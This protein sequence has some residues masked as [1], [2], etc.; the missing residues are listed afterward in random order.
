MVERQAT[1]STLKSYHVSVK[2]NKQNIISKS[3][4]FKKKA[5]AEAIIFGY[6][7]MR[8]ALVSQMKEK[9]MHK[10][11]YER[12]K[13]W[14]GKVTQRAKVLGEAE[15]EESTRRPGKGNT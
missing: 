5:E 2:T 10:R 7:F 4:N 12:R 8:S 1:C 11:A 13:S 9:A 14:G 15:G 6:Y 3:N